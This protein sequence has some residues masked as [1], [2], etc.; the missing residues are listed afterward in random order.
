MGICRVPLENTASPI[1]HSSYWVNGCLSCFGH[2]TRSVHR[3]TASFKSGSGKSHQ[4]GNEKRAS[5]QC[6]ISLRDPGT[7]PA[8]FLQHRLR[9]GTA[10]GAARLHVNWQVLVNAAAFFA[11]NLQNDFTIL[12]ASASTDLLV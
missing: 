2:P 8:D 7:N 5:R 11:G 4:I 9:L 10:T 3:R 12:G 1:G 6:L